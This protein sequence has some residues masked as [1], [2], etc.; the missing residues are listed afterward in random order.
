MQGS[1]GGASY[2]CPRIISPRLYKK[3]VQKTHSR[4]SFYYTLRA[5]VNIFVFNELVSQK[6]SIVHARVRE[7]IS[8]SRTPYATVKWNMRNSPYGQGVSGDLFRGRPSTLDG[9]NLVGSRLQIS[10]IVHK[11]SNLSC[12]GRVACCTALMYIISSLFSTSSQSLCYFTWI[13]FFCELLQRFH[14]LYT[15]RERLEHSIIA[16]CNK[17]QKEPI[18]KAL[19]DTRDAAVYHIYI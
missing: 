8:S 3:K 14:P 7:L 2:F 10:K 17:L 1:Y 6:L 12:G 15:S 16:Q 13:I 19:T 5:F 11:F 18:F 9:I 4:Y